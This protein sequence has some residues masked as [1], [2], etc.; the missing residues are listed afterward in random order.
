V[1]K[2]RQIVR[3]LRGDIPIHVLKSRGLIAGENLHL[4]PGCII[5]LRSAYLIQLGHDVTL[6]PGVVILAHDAST[7]RHLGVSRIG[8]VSVGNRVFVGA[9]AIILPGVTIGD[10]S[11]VGAGS[12]VTRDVEEGSIVAGNPARHVG[13]TAEYVDR[14]RAGMRSGRVWPETWEEH[15]GVPPTEVQQA[16]LEALRSG[17]AVYVD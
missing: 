16:Q 12:V 8:A 2:L 5:D 3:R 9:R 15:Q 13:E 4:G 7:K 10:N 17:T 11:I 1:H 14:H 6:A